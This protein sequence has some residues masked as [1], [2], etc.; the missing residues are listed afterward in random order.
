MESPVLEIPIYFKLTALF[1]LVLLKI[2]RMDKILV[3]GGAGFIGS[4]LVKQLCEAGHKVVVAD[5]L[6]RG[7]KLSNDVLNNIEMHHVD[8]RDR[9]S[10]IRISKGCDVI[11][12]FAAVLGVDV[13]ADSPISTMD[14]EVIGMKNVCDAAILNGINKI[15][16]ASTSGIYGYSAINQSFSE[17]IIVDPRTSYAIAKRYN[18][19]YLS[20]MYEERGLN[21]ISLR[22]FNI[23]GPGQDTRMVIPRFIDQA[24]KNLPITIFGNG[25]QTRDFT[26]IDDTIKACLLLSEKVNG[27]EIYNI[28]N[29]NEVSILTV[30]NEIKRLTQSNSELTFMEAPKK[31]YDYEVERRIGNSEKLFNIT[32]YKPLT[33]LEEGLISILKN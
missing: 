14:T 26:Y 21:S 25:K 8:V 2:E 9:E 18:E 22:F 27:V 23:Y 12:H 13:V 3:T 24:L 17:N 30:A 5:I 6:L 16:Y 31:R 19:I 11:Y 33:S 32:G 10:I 20:A 15:I 29:E 7:N 1:L 28:A 4:H